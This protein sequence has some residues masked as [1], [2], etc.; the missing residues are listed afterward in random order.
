MSS[1]SD[2]LLVADMREAVDNILRYVI[3]MSEAEF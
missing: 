2:E 1:R 3:N